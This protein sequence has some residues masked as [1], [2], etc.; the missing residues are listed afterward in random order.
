METGYP[1]PQLQRPQWLSLNG[2]W[3]FR[4]DDERRCTPPVGHRRTGRCSSR[5]RSRPSRPRAASATR[6]FHPACWYE[7]DFELAAATSGRVIL[8]FGAVDYAARVWV[9]GVLAVE[10]EGG[11]TPFSAD[12]TALLNAVGPADDHG[13]RRGRSARPRQAARQ[14][15]LAARAARASGTRAPPASGR[16][17]GSSG[18]A[19]TYV[20]TIRWT[21]D[22]ENFAIG[23][24]ARIGGDAGGELCA[25][26]RLHARRAR[27]RARPLPRRRPRGRPP[28]R[29]VRSRASTTSATSCCGAP[30]G[31]P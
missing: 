16:R 29:A 15:G 6:G 1:R 14:A 24:E 21:P 11:H 23:F 30:S 17:C 5:C 22:V 9:N 18:R 10:H 4:F 3:R 12:I 31:R 13:P 25:R 8:H 26:G 28:D 7:R 19:A 27:A 2:A 20:E